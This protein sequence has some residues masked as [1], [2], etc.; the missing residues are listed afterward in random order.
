MYFSENS[1]L[2][3][4]KTL[5][6]RMSTLDLTISATNSND[7]MDGS[8]C[9]EQSAGY[10]GRITRNRPSG[11]SESRLRGVRNPLIARERTSSTFSSDTALTKAE[12]KK[13]YMNKKL[14]RMKVTALETIFEETDA[15]SNLGHNNNNVVSNNTVIFGSRKIKRSLSCSDG[16]PSK[17]VRSKQARRAATKLGYKRKFRKISD[18][19]FRQRISLC[20]NDIQTMSTISFDGSLDD[21]NIQSIDETV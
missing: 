16:H 14:G 8:W 2:D 13:L 5:E 19:T 10:S 4:V 18:E 7:T 21:D 9:A 15:D 3:S 20:D 17:T 6:K 1:Q 11:T 12:L